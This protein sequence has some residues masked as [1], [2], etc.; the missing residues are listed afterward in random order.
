MKSVQ[1][2]LLITSISLSSCFMIENSGRADS[3]V[4]K[5]KRNFDVKKFIDT[6]Q[7][8][9]FLYFINETDFETGLVK[10][11]STANS[12]ASIAAMG[13]ALPVWAIGAENLWISRNEAAQ[14]TLNMLK[15]LLYSK[16]S[17]EPDATGYKGLYYHFLDMKTGKRTWNSELS[18]IDTAWLL[19]GIIFAS[20]Y[21]NRQNPVEE[22]IRRFSDSLIARV[23]WDW[24]TSKYENEFLGTIT[25][26]WKPESGFDKI[27]WVGY[28]EGLFLY[29]LAAGLGYNNYK[30]AYKKWLSTYR[31]KEP[32]KGLS[33]VIFPP[34]FGH[35]YPHMYIDFRNLRD[36]FMRKKNIDYFENSRRAVLTQ[37]KYAIL[38]PQDWKGYDSLTWGLTA[39]D[40]PGPAFN[41]NGKKFNWYIA[42]GTSGPEIVMNDDGTIAPT[43]AAASIVFAPELVAKT[44]FNMFVKYGK[45]GLWGKYGFVDAFNPTLNWYDKDYLAIDQGPIVIMIQN[46]K[47]GFVWKYTMKDSII[48][49]GLKKL[50]FVKIS[51]N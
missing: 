13:F 22:K 18:T 27:G 5:N 32:F 43:A 30:T 41:D 33:H 6:L 8:R 34:L 16:Q 37:W 50:G 2:F 10:D 45:K 35:Q 14:R 40:G 4:Y 17:P 31:W 42:R 7:H 46:Y 44:V 47:N 19:G 36:E 12:P 23:D 51:G 21:F 39:C 28:N 20:N 1:I 15:F 11:R 26:G 24:L 48:I 9:T 49:N 3:F 29:I 38:N 25:L